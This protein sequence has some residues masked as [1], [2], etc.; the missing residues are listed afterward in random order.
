MHAIIFCGIQAS[1][2]ST[3]YREHFFNTHMR[4]SLDLLRTRNREN[5]F[6][7]LC[8]QTQ[9]PFVVDNTNPTAAERARYIAL[10]KAA[11]YKVTCYFFESSSK[12]AL[13]RNS[14]RT[15]RFLVP[16]KG[17]FGTHKKLQTPQLEEGYDS[18]YRV[19]LLPSGN[20]EVDLIAT[21]EAL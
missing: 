12:D 9:L 2:K 14:T 21:Q 13:L 7:E 5:R 6:L 17:I 3:F 19:K 11:R 16:P 8:L 4:I 20:Y 15:G 1:G 18:L 10:A